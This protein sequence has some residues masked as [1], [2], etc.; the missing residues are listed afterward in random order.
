MSL[1]SAPTPELP[2]RVGGDQPISRMLRYYIREDRY[3][4]RGGVPRAR[5]VRESVDAIMRAMNVL[6]EWLREEY[7]VFEYATDVVRFAAWQDYSPE[8]DAQLRRLRSCILSPVRQ[9]AQV[10]EEAALAW[11]ESCGP[12]T[13]FVMKLKTRPPTLAELREP[14]ITSTL[15]HF[16]QTAMERSNRNI[17]E[18]PAAPRDILSRS[19]AVIAELQDVASN[20]EKAGRI[21]LTFPLGVPS[22]EQKKS[23]DHARANNQRPHLQEQIELLVELQS[24]RSLIDNF[25]AKSGSNVDAFERATKSP[26]KQN[27]VDAAEQIRQL[28]T[29]GVADIALKATG[30][31]S[32]ELRG[33]TK[34]PLV[35]GKPISRV[36]TGAEYSALAALVE[37]ERYPITTPELEEATNDTNATKY[38]RL[39]AE[40]PEFRDV[41]RTPMGKKN[42]G[43]SIQ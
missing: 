2:I 33:E 35:R 6:E 14:T 8:R 4:L 17:A 3:I 19:L 7:S 32:I 12:L 21:K 30:S 15:Q 37:A 34:R 9:C 29:S 24:D 28:F 22:S 36:L 41:I 42:A 5:A 25:A 40:M 13:K 23:L 1:A 18:P 20:I 11:S 27:L 39:L 10:V 16:I 26:C 38:I 31:R 43:F